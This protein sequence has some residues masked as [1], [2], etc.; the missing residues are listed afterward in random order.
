MLAG[1]N[2]GFGRSAAGFGEHQI[3]VILSEMAL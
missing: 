1:F 2:I 3:D